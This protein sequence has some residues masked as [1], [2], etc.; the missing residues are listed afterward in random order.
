MYFTIL[1]YRICQ[2]MVKM[3]Y[4][5]NIWFSLFCYKFSSH[6]HYTL[7]KD[8]IRWS[9]VYTLE[10]ILEG[11]CAFFCKHPAEAFLIFSTNIN[12]LCNLMN[13]SWIKLSKKKKTFKITDKILRK[14]HFFTKRIRV[15]ITMLR[16]WSLLKQRLCFGDFGARKGHSNC[17][18]QPLVFRE[19]L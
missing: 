1:N 5:K 2:K 6:K 4:F 13:I 14:F 18:L 9:V 3:G 17:R 10:I 12:Y 8:M 11:T 7:I 15:S 19:A 16:P